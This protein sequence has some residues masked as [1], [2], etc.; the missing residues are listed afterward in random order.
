ML[1][2][3]VAIDNARRTHLRATVRLAEA[4]TGVIRPIFFCDLKDANSPSPRPPVCQT[5]STT[6]NSNS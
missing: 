3:P 4:V 1:V 2:T 5:R 6:Y